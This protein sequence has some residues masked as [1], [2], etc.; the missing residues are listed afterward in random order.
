[1]IPIGLGACAW[2]LAVGQWRLAIAAAIF[3]LPVGA[4]E[5]YLSRKRTLGVLADSIEKGAE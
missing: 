5:A 3:V 1:M 2:D 4:Y